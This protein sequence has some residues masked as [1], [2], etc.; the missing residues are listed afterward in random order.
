[1][2]EP[3]QT[4][5]SSACRPFYLFFILRRAYPNQYQLSSTCSPF[6]QFPSTCRPFLPLQVF[7]H[8]MVSLAKPTSVYINP[9]AGLLST[10]QSACLILNNSMWAG[11]HGIFFPGLHI[12]SSEFPIGGPLLNTNR[13]EVLFEM[14][15]NVGD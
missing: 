14:C 3:H 13:N 6:I 8:F 1:M 2:T 5:F 4:Q 15:L 9:V 12:C 10:F 11:F 7:F